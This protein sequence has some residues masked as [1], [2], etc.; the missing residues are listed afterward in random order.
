VSTVVDANVV[1]AWQTPGHTF[2]DVAVRLIGEAEPPLVL[3]ELNLAEV[4]VGLP[5]PS[6]DSAID[7]LT[8]MGFTFVTTSAVEVAAARLD[9]R[10]RMPDACVVAAA[11]QMGAGAVLTLDETLAAAARGAGLAVASDESR[12]H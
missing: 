4:L 5:R 8:A 3:H 9:T 12:P 10:L 2:H 11:R 1:I 6:W 7:T